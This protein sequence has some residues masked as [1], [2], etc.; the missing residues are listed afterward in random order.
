MCVCVCVCMCVC[1]LKFKNL[2]KIF[3]KGKKKDFSQ[4]HFFRVA[5]SFIRYS[6]SSK[7]FDN[8]S[9]SDYHF[10]PPIHPIIL[11]RKSNDFKILPQT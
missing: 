4:K 10:R 8:M 6:Q 2:V 5:T 3:N 1:V 11:F 7:I 9:A